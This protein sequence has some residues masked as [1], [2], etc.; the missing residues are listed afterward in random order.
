MKK[1]HCPEI[2]PV[3]PRTRQYVEKM[4]EIV[5]KRQCL[6]NTVIIATKLLKNDSKYAI[7]LPCLR[8]LHQKSAN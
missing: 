4:K 1:K 2:V 3:K 7:Q 8:D 6:L 5:S